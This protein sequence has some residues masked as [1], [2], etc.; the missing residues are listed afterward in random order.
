MQIVL[1]LRTTIRL[2]IL[3]LTIAGF[4]LTHAH[5]APDTKTIGLVTG[6]ETGTYMAFGQDMAAIANKEGL[7]LDVKASKGTVDN[8]KRIT[9][10]NENAGLGI[11]QSDLMI[12]L[13]RSKDPNSRALAKQ[14]RLVF[15]FHT[16][17]IHVLANRSI[18]NLTDLAGKR[19]VIG[20]ARSG[21]KITASNIFAILD[22]KPAQY[23][24]LSPPEGVVAVLSGEAD[25]MIFIGGKPVQLFT[26]LGELRTAQD[27][28]NKHL[29]DAV[30]F[31][32]VDN[33][34][35]LQLYSKASI[36]AQ[37]Y[38]FVDKEIPTISVT[39]LLISYDFSSRHNAYYTARC[40]QLATLGKVIRN[41][42]ATLRE[43]GHPKW[44]DVDLSREVLNWKRDSCSWSMATGASD[45]PKASNALEKDLLSI[46][47][48]PQD[49]AAQ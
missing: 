28:K 4:T 10:I 16:E 11:V 38:T 7:K 32:P 6:P 29:L 47:S 14:L 44:K 13:S 42:L 41:N 24:E 25:A 48:K 18:Q 31:V 39:A 3:S 40:N 17:E 46:I 49:S 27:G 15:P 2:C 22:I 19:V 35:L 12:M 34:A 1:S 21:S 37:D 45:A 23:I 5:A 36:S 20:D 26:N 30:H 43:N 9:S 8:I 33:P